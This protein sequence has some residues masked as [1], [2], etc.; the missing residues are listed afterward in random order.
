MPRKSKKQEL[1]VRQDTAA[2]FLFDEE[3]LPVRNDVVSAVREGRYKHTGAR[4]LEN[5]ELA[6]QMVEKLTLGWGLKRIAK[7]MH[8]SKHS[9]REAR[10]TLVRQGKLAPYKERVVKL[11]EE[12]VEVGASAYLDALEEGDVPAGQI[13]VGMGIVFDKRALAM[14]EPTAI[15]AGLAGPA[16]EELSVERLNAWFA[17]LKPLVI[18]EKP[19]PTDAPS[20]GKEGEAA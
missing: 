19:A 3:Q 20:S 7:A 1:A 14:G 12:I 17:G 9:V 2:P 18:E 15:G 6:L 4:L 10:D 16:S 11:F 8:V 13:P 5:E